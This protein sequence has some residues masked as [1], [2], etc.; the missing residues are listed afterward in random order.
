MQQTNKQKIN[1][2]HDAYGKDCLSR[3]EVAI[4]FLKGHLPK[5]LVD[6]L[7]LD[8]L[9]L[10]KGSFVDSLFQFGA[11]PDNKLKCYHGQ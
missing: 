9:E 6:M 1:Q 4:D 7:D 10:T 2:A 11:V 3:K 5:E 8:S